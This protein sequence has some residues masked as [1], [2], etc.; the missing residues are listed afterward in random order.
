MKSEETANLLLPSKNLLLSS[1]KI[2]LLGELAHSASQIELNRPWRSQ[3]T[4]THG[5]PE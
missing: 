2:L 3:I 1:A 5:R 4:I